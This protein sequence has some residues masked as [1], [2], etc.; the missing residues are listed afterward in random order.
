MKGGKQM[1]YILFAVATVI[2]V[3]L[4][5]MNGFADETQKETPGE[6]AFSGHCM[7]CHPGGD[8]IFNPAKTLHKKDLDAN[9]IK[10]PEDIIQIMRNPG[11][12]MTKFDKD[13]IPDNVAKEIAA[14]VLKNLK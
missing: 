1:K 8:N 7:A 5:F 9:N 10:S 11:P 14:Y 2:A 3:S 4:F 6:S 13:I 12:Q